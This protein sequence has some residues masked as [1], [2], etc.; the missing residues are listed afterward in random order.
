MLLNF[1]V[2]TPEDKITRPVKVHIIKVSIKGS[3]IETN[4][5]STE[6]LV[7]EVA[8]AIGADPC[9]A[10]LEYKPLATPY[11]NAREK[12]APKKP[13]QQKSP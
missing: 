10:S 12:D 3:S 4:P 11:V 13:Q 2:Q 7:F 1:S 5:S 9:P 6:C 8:W